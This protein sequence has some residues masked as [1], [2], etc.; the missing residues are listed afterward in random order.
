MSEKEDETPDVEVEIT[1]GKT[2]RINFS[3]LEWFI[4]MAGASAIAMITGVAL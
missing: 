1:N 2:V 3:P 4:I